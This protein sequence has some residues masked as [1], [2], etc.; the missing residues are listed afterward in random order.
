MPKGVY[1][2]T[3]KE[4]ERLRAMVGQ[5]HSAETRAKLSAARTRTIGAESIRRDGR[6][7]VKVSECNRSNKDWRKRAHLIWIAAHGLIPK[8]CDVHH[9]NEDVAD[10]RLENLRCLTKAEHMRHHSPRRYPLGGS[11]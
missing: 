5:K 1:E 11:V 7:Y 8:G 3:Q 4:L 2:R 10:D 6:V 9:E